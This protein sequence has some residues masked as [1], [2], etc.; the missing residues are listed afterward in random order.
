M[1]APDN[2]FCYIF[3]YMIYGKEQDGRLLMFDIHK[4]SQRAPRFIEEKLHR[5]YNTDMMWIIF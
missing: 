4:M 3:P 2:D 1:G 5:I